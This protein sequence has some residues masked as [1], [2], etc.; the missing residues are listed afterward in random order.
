ML[1]NLFSQDRNSITIEIE[2]QLL[3]KRAHHHVGIEHMI[4][5]ELMQFH[6]RPSTNVPHTPTSWA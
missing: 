2:D 6:S 4:P 5:Q 3:P 1:T